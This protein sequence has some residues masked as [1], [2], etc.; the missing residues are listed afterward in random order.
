VTNEQ[1]ELMERR[2]AGFDQWLA[3]RLPVL[4]HF[5]AALELPTPSLIVAEPERY[6]PPIDAWLR[7]QVIESDDWVWIVT[8]VGYFIGE[9]LI[10]RFGG[11]WLV[12][13]APDSRF[14]ARHVVGRLHRVS[15]PAAIT[16]PFEIATAYL[17]QP[18]GRSLVAILEEVC[19]ELLRA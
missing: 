11:C 3:E 8:R 4:H 16:D 18:P 5:A 19:A 1:R 13:D 2:R 14:F 17:K 15:N 9:V 7:D 10:H 6:L 12:C